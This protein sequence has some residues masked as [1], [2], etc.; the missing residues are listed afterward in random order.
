MT[1][2]LATDVPSGQPPGDVPRVRQ[3]LRCNTTF[4]SEWSGER[5]CSRCKRSNAW[6]SGTPLTSRPSSNKR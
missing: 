4:P 1:D 5:V 2:S 3:C 6:R